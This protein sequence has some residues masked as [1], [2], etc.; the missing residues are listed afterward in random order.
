M[1]EPTKYMWPLAVLGGAVEPNFTVPPG[2][3]FGITVDAE[4]AIRYV[5]DVPPAATTSR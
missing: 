5:G 1:S 4:F 2:G 3:W